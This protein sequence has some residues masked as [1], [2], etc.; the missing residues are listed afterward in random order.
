MIPGGARA[1]HRRFQ[2]AS[3]RCTG[4]VRLVRR[5]ASFG[6]LRRVHERVSGATHDHRK[7][8][9]HRAHRLSNRGFQGADDLQPLLR[10]CG[11]RRR[12]R[13]H[14]RQG[15]RL[16]VV[17]A[18]PVQPDQH[19]RLADHHAAQG[20]DRGPGRRRHADGA[21]RRSVQRHPE[22]SRRIAARATCS[23]APDSCAASSARDG[24]L[25]GARALVVGS[26]GVG[27]A[28]A[29]SFAAAGVS[30]LGV[31]DANQRRRPTRSPSGCASTIRSIEVASGSKDPAGFDVVVNA[32]PL[33]HE[34]R[35]IRCRWTSTAS[36]RRRSSAKS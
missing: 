20:H 33:G 34:G 23:T 36:R 22:A 19:S 5:L 3:A 4:N 14:G 26:G 9:S 12:R 31:F 28:I 15:G 17:P 18:A 16:S 10:P 35:A 11:N 7:D 6:R 25:K 13:P 2:P 30:A 32:T 27:S 29:A 21:D 24:L 8:N 1:A